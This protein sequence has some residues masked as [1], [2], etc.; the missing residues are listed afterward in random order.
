MVYYFNSTRREYQKARDNVEEI[1]ISTPRKEDEE[2]VILRGRIEFFNEARGFGLSKTLQ[3][4]KN[5]SF[6]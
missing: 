6:T 5:I 1:M 3:E 4:L 2:P